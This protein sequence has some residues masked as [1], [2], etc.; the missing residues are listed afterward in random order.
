M[1]DSIS[2]D[3]IELIIGETPFDTMRDYLNFQGIENGNSEESTVF[4]SQ[5]SL[6]QIGNDDGTDFLNETGLLFWFNIQIGLAIKKNK[7]PL[8]EVLEGGTSSKLELGCS[9][10]LGQQDF[11][12]YYNTVSENKIDLETL[13]R[14]NTV[15]NN[16]V[17]KENTDK[18]DK[19]KKIKNRLYQARAPHEK[20]L[21]TDKDLKRSALKRRLALTQ[22]NKNRKQQQSFYPMLDNLLNCDKLIKDNNTDSQDNNKG[23]E[24]VNELLDEIS[25]ES[26]TLSSTISTARTSTSVSGSN[27]PTSEVDTEFTKK[28]S[29]RLEQ[30]K[31]CEYAEDINL[32]KDLLN[33][34]LKSI[35]V[36][37]DSLDAL[38][39]SSLKDDD[40]EFLER[41][42][43][44]KLQGKTL[45]DE[46]LE[47]FNEL[48]TDK[49]LQEL[50]KQYENHNKN[51][52]AL[53]L[54]VAKL[55]TKDDLKV[56]KEN[57]ID[58]NSKQIN[59]AKNA[60]LGEIKNIPENISEK[61]EKFIN[62]PSQF[63]AILTKAIS[64]ANNEYQ[65]KYTDILKHFQ[66]VIELSNTNNK[67]LQDKLTENTT[68]LSEVKQLLKSPKS[69]ELTEIIPLLKELKERRDIISS[70]E[71][72]SKN[73]DIASIVTTLIESLESK[74]KELQGAHK[75]LSDKEIQELNKSIRA[76]EQE[77]HKIKTELD[78]K[79]KELKSVSSTAAEVTENPPAELEKVVE[80][81]KP[82]TE[83]S[84]TASNPQ[85]SEKDSQS[86]EKDSQ[87]SEKDSQSSEK[88]SQSSEKKETV[89]LVSGGGSSQEVP[90]TTNDSRALINYAEKLA[91]TLVTKDNNDKRIIDV[92]VPGPFKN[93]NE[94]VN[95][96]KNL[97]I[98]NMEE[99]ENKYDDDDDTEPDQDKFDAEE[100]KQAE[101]EKATNKKKE[102]KEEEEK[103]QEEDEET[104]RK[105]AVTKTEIDAEIKKEDE[106]KNQTSNGAV[107]DLISDE[108][109][110]IK[111]TKEAIGD[112]LKTKRTVAVD[113]TVVEGKHVLLTKPQMEEIRNKIKEKIS[114]SDISAED[115]KKDPERVKRILKESFTVTDLES[116]DSLKDIDI[117]ET[118]VT[119]LIDQTTD[120]AKTVQKEKFD[121]TIRRINKGIIG[122]SFLNH[123]KGNHDDSLKDLYSLLGFRNKGAPK[124]LKDDMEFLDI[125]MEVNIHRNMISKEFRRLQ[126][127]MT[128]YVQSKNKERGNDGSHDLKSTIIN[129]AKQILRKKINEKKIQAKLKQKP[130]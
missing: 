84:A 28:L 115:I 35:K 61:L 37:K 15:E 11:S 1:A 62:D 72:T 16:N 88:D 92:I 126:G 4:E 60:L 111:L 114:K 113:G 91:P 75:S 90:V 31:N 45:S 39:G 101:I 41:L 19:I 50:K 121:D 78:E 89:L 3:D 12:F 40:K 2:E 74:N 98:K 32:I 54:K 5:T 129:K 105:D 63:Q 107:K 109:H 22:T 27:T 123:G 48:A 68:A 58:E 77:N 49:S 64:E 104:E 82:L 59:E 102:E 47:K 6:K 103:Q 118:L 14:P 46:Q 23:T 80:Y 55:A 112:G 13:S 122:K 108:L 85:S 106:T 20:N 70:S 124:F 33:E 10:T 100:D 18:I 81:V 93:K 26:S 29:T 8:S 44:N 95:K 69:P 56:T 125:M 21:T 130:H 71:Q 7:V 99:G 51:I 38:Q 128:D 119:N 53:N 110:S 43:S 127:Y 79:G 30:L 83:S 87:S 36:Y 25:R 52:L 116:I 117:P 34:I 42:F 94:V 86:S 17:S 57:I 67:L 9:E 76:L 73:N 96:L 24:E 97:D 65:A 66:T 120:I